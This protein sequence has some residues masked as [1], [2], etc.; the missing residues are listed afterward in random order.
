MIA[1][2][3]YLYIII[4]YTRDILKCCIFTVEERVKEHVISCKSRNIEWWSI[5]SISISHPMN[6][7]CAY[8]WT[9]ENGRMS[10]FKPN[11]LNY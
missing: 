3:L 2:G 11:S 1:Y 10:N 7:R 6:L 9:L 4:G 8:M 5:E